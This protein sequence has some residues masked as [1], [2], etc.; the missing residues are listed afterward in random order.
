VLRS[1]VNLPDNPLRKESAEASLAGSFFPDVGTLRHEVAS[2]CH[3]PTEWRVISLG[4]PSPDRLGYGLTIRQAEFKD[5]PHRDG[6]RR[7][8]VEAS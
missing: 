7:V 6:H 2:P 3:A 4:E 8:P 5:G 1:V